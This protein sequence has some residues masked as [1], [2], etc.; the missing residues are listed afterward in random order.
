M[1]VIITWNSLDFGT[2]EEP[3]CGICHIAQ[4]NAN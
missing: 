4:N 2:K 3:T 1:S